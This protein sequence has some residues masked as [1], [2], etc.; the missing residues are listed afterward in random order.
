MNTQIQLTAEIVKNIKKNKYYTE[1]NFLNDANAYI[2]AI[3][4]NRMINVIGNVS[5]SGMSRTIKF[6]SCEIG[7]HNGE[8]KCYQRQ[9]T[10]LFRS[11][12][13][14]ET[15]NNWGYFRISGCGM[16][17]VFHTNYCIMHDFER[18]GLISQEQCEKLAQMTPNT[19]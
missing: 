11:L 3:K 9:Y 5:A 2:D 13:Y 17:M 15:K 10:C 16:D 1:E 7:K 12:G 8:T 18:I 14:N 6:T 19:I 4:E